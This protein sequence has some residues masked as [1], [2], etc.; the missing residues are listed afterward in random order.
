M[1][2]FGGIALGF[3]VPALGLELLSLI[4]YLITGSLT[5][6]KWAAFTGLGLCIISLASLQLG[7]I[8]DMLNRHRIYLEELLYERRMR[9]QR[10]SRDP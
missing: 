1:P 3:F 2:F 9:Q 7:T 5:P 4:H 10:D 6:H 8:G